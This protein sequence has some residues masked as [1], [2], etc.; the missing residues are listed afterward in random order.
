MD[1][2]SIRCHVL[3]IQLSGTQRGSFPGLETN[4]NYRLVT[5]KSTSP[6]FFLS[7]TNFLLYVYHS[8]LSNFINYIILKQGFMQDENVG[9][10][11]IGKL[12][13]ERAVGCFGTPQLK[14]AARFPMPQLERVTCFA[15]PQLERA[16]RFPNVPSRVAT[17]FRMF[18]FEHE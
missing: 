1:R 17:R 2:E 9:C 4:W 12:L 13:F 18:Q 5:W 16:T 7:N 8:K 11:D 15:M 3:D 6:D 10:H 14:R